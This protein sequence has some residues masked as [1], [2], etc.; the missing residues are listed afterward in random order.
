MRAAAKAWAVHEA[1]ALLA[2]CVASLVIAA[3]G[4]Q[5]WDAPSFSVPWAYDQDALS[6]LAAFKGI[7]DHGW[8]WTDASLGAPHGLDYYDFGSLGP[9][10]LHWAIAWV[11]TRFTGQPGVVYNLFLL[12]TFPLT[13]LT[14]YLSLRWLDVGRGAAAAVAVVFA[15]VPFHFFR[16]LNGHLLLADYAVIPL[17]VFLAV[18]VVLRRPLFTGGLRSPT[19]VRT[20]VI[21]ALIACTGIYYAAFLVVLLAV[22][23][24]AARLERDDRNVTLLNG[25]GALAAIV[26]VLI[27]NLLPTILYHRA[28]GANDFTG[29][30]EADDSLKFGL[31]L[32]AQVLPSPAHR[33]GPARTLAGQYWDLV[34]PT[35]EGNPWGGTLSVLGLLILATALGVALVGGVA[36]RFLCDVRLR[37]TALIALAAVL[38]GATGA[39]GAFVAFVLNPS[40]RAWNRISIVVVFCALVAVAIALEAIGARL[41]GR[42]GAYAALL[43]AVV[44]FAGWDQTNASSRPDYARLQARWDGDAAFVGRISGLLGGRGMVYQLPYMEFPETAKVVGMTDYQPLRG[45]LH[46]PGA[47][48]WSYGAM[49]GRPADFQVDADRLP[50]AT[51]LRAAALAGFGGVWLDRDGYLGTDRDQVST[52][53]RVSGQRPFAD[54]TGKLVFADLRPLRRELAATL[55]P[56]EQAAA[57]A[58]LLHPL[59]VEYG[60]GIGLAATDPRRGTTTRTLA[61]SGTVA[62]TN[63][64]DDARTVRLTTTPNQDV[65][66]TLDGQPLATLDAGDP[67]DIAFTVQPGEH[68]LGLTTLHGGTILH[69][70]VIEDSALAALD[71]AS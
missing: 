2:A 53:A 17:G 57:A 68:M 18:S 44:V 60:T 22:A 27:L 49:K 36:G 21:C 56:A 32:I 45:P 50:L 61:A 14:G 24:L 70:P 16:G 42:A 6:L 62:L 37:A 23:V 29:A 65:T 28:H 26:A 8:I 63:P 71:D 64:Q 11:I 39:G 25:M 55:A 47:M 48:G 5:L 51:Q 46:A 35:T 69:D 13:A 43:V 31:S 33:F 54:R 38:L 19:S 30:R 20:L 1:P 4:L 41:R 52:L 58:A 9:D 59:D 15:V 12:I 67:G 66:V 10:N 3:I 40:I 7:H 34:S